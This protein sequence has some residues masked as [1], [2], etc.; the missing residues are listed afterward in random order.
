MNAGSSEGQS[1]AE[2][3]GL[4]MLV[5]SDLLLFFMI[6]CPYQS[7]QSNQSALCKSDV[8]KHDFSVV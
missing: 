4:W 3:T 2:V 7:L 1:T 8:E 5:T 6:I